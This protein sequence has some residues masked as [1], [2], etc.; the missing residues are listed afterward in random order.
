M[1]EEYK[2]GPGKPPKEHRFS[3]VNQP[4]PSKKRV[5]KMKTRL[6]RYIEANLDDMIEAMIKE[7]KEGN[8]TAF[9][10]I[11]DRAYGKVTDKI[12]HSGG[13]EQRLNSDQV[14]EEIDKLLELRERDK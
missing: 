9:D 8:V 6:K 7:A 1:E 10:K 2:V 5:P 11:L 4:D 3:S 13:I 14:K 12:E